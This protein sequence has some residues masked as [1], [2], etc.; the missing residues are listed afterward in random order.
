[1]DRVL[2]E[3]LVARSTA[4]DVLPGSLIVE[5]ELVR[6]DSHNVSIFVVGVFYEEWYPTAKQIEGDWDLLMY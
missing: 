6:R 1:M 5:T 4:I 2:V 3:V